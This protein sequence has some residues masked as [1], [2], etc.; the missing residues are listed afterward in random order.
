MTQSNITHA[1]PIICKAKTVL[2]I[3][4]FIVMASFILE[5]APVWAQEDTWSA[6]VNGFVGGKY[7]SEK[8]WGSADLQIQYGVEV[9][10][11]PKGWK[12]ELVLGIFRSSGS[13][14]K[15]INDKSGFPFITP[16]IVTES[17]KGETFEVQLGVKKIWRPLKRAH[18]FISGGATAVRAKLEDRLNNLLDSNTGVG[19]WLGGGVYW[20]FFQHVNLG[21]V[22]KYSRTRVSLLDKNRDA[23]GVQ[24]GYLAGFHW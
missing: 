24:I 2:T 12:G 17:T 9:D 5:R 6:N 1:F 21:A 13:G 14:H 10:F 16:P 15:Y 4:L 20:T 23:G 11:R 18:P 8:E 7:L 19:Y 3:F 22:V